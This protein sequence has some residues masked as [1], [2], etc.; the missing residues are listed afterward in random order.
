VTVELAVLSRV[1]FRGQEITGPRLRGLL[2][3]LAG[4]PNGCGAGRLVDGLWPDDQPDNPTKALQ[5]LVSRIRAQ[6][7]DGLIVRTP[8]GYRLALTGQQ[9][10]A[11]AVLHHAAQAAAHAR[12]GDHRQALDHAEAGL[13]L[14]DGPPEPTKP[15][16]PLAELRAERAVT[17]RT[18]V[19]ARA[20]AL[21][22][23]GKHAEAVEPLTDLAAEYPRD[24]E[25]LLELL[26]AEATA[27]SPAA[28]MA[29]Y[30]AYRRVL[31]DEL[32]ADPGPA[33]RTAHQELLRDEQ[34]TARHGVA[35]EPNPLLGRDDDLDAIAGLL[36][37]ARVVSVV[38][39]GGLGK[40]RVAHAV[41]RTS[42]RRTV[43]FVSLAGIAGDGDV[44]AEVASS[45]GVVELAGRDPVAGIVEA[46]G[47][48]ALLVLDNC[49]H[50]LARAADLVATLVA[51]ARDLRILT[52][53]R[54]PLGLSSE[55]VYLL[56]E[57]DQATTEELFRQRALAARPGVELP[58]DAVAELCARL[59]GLPLAVELA[60]A[61]VRVLPV[62]EINRR[63]ADRFALLRS[64]R[65][66]APERH[67]TLWAVVDWSWH[68]LDEDGRAALR[69]LAILPGGFTEEAADR[70]L[71]RAA[72][73]TLGHLLDQSLLKVADTPEGTRFRMLET[74]REFGE[75]RLAE[76]GDTDRA[77]D[78]FLAWARDFARRHHL[79][80]FGPDPVQVTDLLRVEQDNLRLALR[81]GL[82]R[83]D[84][85]SVA[86]ATALLA[87]LSTV[88]GDNARAGLLARETAQLF[89]HY[90]PEAQ[91][92]EVARTA[93]TLTLINALAVQA[94]GIARMVC[95]LRRLPSAPPDAPVRALAVVLA[96]PGVLR[97]DRTALEAMFAGDEPQVAA[98]A[99][100]I[101]GYLA[102]HEGDLAAAIDL[103]TPALGLWG[104]DTAPWLW[105]LALARLGE[106]TQRVERSAEALEYFGQAI[107]LLDR[108]GAHRDVVGVSWGMMLANLQLG[109]LDDAE[110]WLGRAATD[111]AG[112]PDD[113]VGYLMF[114]L[115]ARAELALARGEVDEG[116][117]L[118]RRAAS[119]WDRLA[120]PADDRRLW[121]LETEAGAVSAHARFDRLD[122]V[123]GLLA[124]LPH[125]LTRLLSAPLEW[126]PVDLVE[127]Q[128]AGA[129]LVALGIA[130][131]AAG[132]PE[133]GVRLVALAEQ[134]RFA[135]GFQPTLKLADVRAMVE[136]A[137]G[138]AYA[139]AMSEYTGLDRDQLRAAVL[140]ALRARASAV[141]PA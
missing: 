63:L 24:E 105:I 14:W 56:P 38:G 85:A 132:R 81:H 34:P 69:A 17:Y 64:A 100:L 48:G 91:D 92:I 57:L 47:A 11:Q 107:R 12:A 70:V 44:T 114:A 25:I 20:L 108:I 67:H 36:T 78:G 138:P 4:E 131:I 18:L 42:T 117:R 2:A 40:T 120:L 31:R 39:P 136:K 122:L 22:R 139:D 135:P 6:L 116:L 74:V 125:R 13:A 77:V 15:G 45:V 29:R 7:G 94:P 73:D 5:I 115:A 128:L 10:D 65:R 55:S 98:V 59:D 109:R 41:G 126:Q 46:L 130:D 61:R 124:E 28:A 95:A 52:T 33:L 106:L 53:S 1:A 82:A 137:D 26:R 16:D 104:T 21:A 112:A 134:Y 23:L 123:P 140:A 87:A 71:G 54:A 32:G 51:V 49:E 141:G 86:A 72:L 75:S 76:S 111:N 103:T 101:M 80:A 129:V 83:A 93:M 79:G 118:W 90:R 8:T 113:D 66:D 89:T 133:I 97:R 121:T 30:D 35:H 119:V 58:D 9:I 60:A 96:A 84:G 127:P 62:A 99:G 19:R 43:H 102:E 88:D 50:V 68:L 110:H 3:L 37:S 27:K